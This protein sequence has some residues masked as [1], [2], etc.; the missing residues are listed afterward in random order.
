MITFLY[1]CCNCGPKEKEIDSKTRCIPI[2]FLCPYCKT[3]EMKLVS[4]IDHDKVHN[5]C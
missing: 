1:E 5:I 2:S 3:R 4:I